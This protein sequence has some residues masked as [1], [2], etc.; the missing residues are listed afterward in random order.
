MKIE[1]E[2]QEEIVAV[3][4]EGRLE[5]YRRDDGSG[6]LRLER[7][8]PLEDLH[9]GPE[10]QEYREADQVALMGTARREAFRIPDGP[11]TREEWGRTRAERDD[12]NYFDYFAKV[13]ARRAWARWMR[14]NAPAE[15]VLQRLAQLRGTDDATARHLV[16]P[17]PKLPENPLEFLP[18]GLDDLDRDAREAA[19]HRA[20]GRPVAGTR[21]S[22]LAML[23]GIDD[24]DLKERVCWLIW[25]GGALHIDGMTMHE[26]RLIADRARILLCDQGRAFLMADGFLEVMEQIASGRPGDR[27]AQ[28]VVDRLLRRLGRPQK[29]GTIVFER[30]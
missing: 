29:Y 14:E 20:D 5:V 30:F 7:R 2:V 16:A 1:I 24:D 9:A 21:E 25:A 19:P 18:E 3:P 11:M 8:D 10:E 15:V 4:T 22:V 13:E 12:N 26:A 28:Q 6:G 17:P 27:S 23:D